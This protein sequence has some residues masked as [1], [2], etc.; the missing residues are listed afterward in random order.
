MVT[1]LLFTVSY[2]DNKLSTGIISYTPVEDKD[3]VYGVLKCKGSTRVG[4]LLN[5]WVPSFVEMY[6]H[7]QSELSFTGT[8]HG[9]S[10]LIDGS[11]NIAASSRKIKDLEMETFYKAKG[12]PPTEMKVSLDALALYV[13]RLNPTP[14]ITLEQLD[15]IFSSTRRQGLEA[16]VNWKQLGWEDKN[17][18]VHLFAKEA[19]ARGFLQKHVL[20]GGEY[21]T[22]N[23]VNDKHLTALSVTDEIEKDKYSIGFGAIGIDNFKVKM[24]P[25]AKR[26]RYPEYAPNTKNIKNEKYPLTRFL[27]IYMDVPPDKPIPKLLYEFCKFML[28]KEGQTIVLKD[29]GVPLSPRLIGI[30]LAKIQ[31]E[32][33]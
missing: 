21:T 1:I 3:S 23:V 6:P 30:E 5:V 32:G 27:Y 9:I 24:L 16:I 26:E 29:G 25:I 31:R 33:I 4:R 15:A 2:A 7:I 8:G 17:I 14:S 18:T 28:S 13:N 22:Q 20:L 12:Y 10:S 11:A 19:G